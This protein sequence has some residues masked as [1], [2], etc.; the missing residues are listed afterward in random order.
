MGVRIAMDD[1]GTG[2]AS[3]SQLARFSF[4]KIKIDRSLV[5]PDGD[6]FKHRAIVRAISAMGA[7]LGIA[8]MA[9]GI[10]TYDQLE[11]IRLDGCGSV[12]GYLFSKPLPADQLE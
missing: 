6:N 12:Q 2:H 7:S 11:R 5:G 4:D 9:E 8:T 1:F 10:E 3:L